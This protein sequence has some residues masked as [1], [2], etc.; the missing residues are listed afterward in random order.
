VLG[1]Q[2]MDRFFHLPPDHGSFDLVLGCGKIMLNRYGGTS[3]SSSTLV[4]E[5]P[6]FDSK[7]PASHRSG[8]TIEGVPESPGPCEGLLN[9]FF[10]QLRITQGFPCVT[11][12]LTAIGK[13]GLTKA[14]CIRGL[15]PVR[16]AP[17]MHPGGDQYPY[18]PDLAV[19]GVEVEWA[20]VPEPGAFTANHTPPTP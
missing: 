19:V 10:G 9:G 1:T 16:H 20:V 11:E 15:W 17:I 3:R 14:L 13:I 5:D 4:D 18:P 2:T 8:I 6:M 7:K 12:Q